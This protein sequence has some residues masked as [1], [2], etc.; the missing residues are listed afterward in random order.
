MDKTSCFGLIFINEKSFTKI[1]KRCFINV[2]MYLRTS[3]VYFWIKNSKKIKRRKIGF[4][5]RKSALKR[6]NG[7]SSAE[8]TVHRRPS[9]HFR[10]K[11]FVLGARAPVSA[12]KRPV[13]VPIWVF[14]F[15]NPILCL[16]K[17]ISNLPNIIWVFKTNNPLVPS[18]I[19][20]CSN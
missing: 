16:V 1:I 4:Q 2:F 19:L 17:S 15:S 18:P 11:N 13:S 7:R 20:A 12:P 9:A 14:V 10:S 6:T 8:I 5:N 3:K